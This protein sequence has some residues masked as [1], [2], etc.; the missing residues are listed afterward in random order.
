M[1]PRRGRRYRGQTVYDS[2]LDAVDASLVLRV[3]VG[4]T[5]AGSGLYAWGRRSENRLGVLMTVV[6]CTYLGWHILIQAHSSSLFTAGIWLSDSWTVLF[7]LFLLSFPEGR[8]NTKFDL[9]ILAMF[10]VVAFPLEFLWLLFFS[11]GGSPENALVVW[12]NS[13]VAD[14]VDSAQRALLVTACVVLAVTL[15]RRWIAASPP[16]RRALIP[17]VVGSA[18]ILVS[19]VMLALDKFDVEFEQRDGLSSARTSRFRSSFWRASSARVLHVRQLESSSSSCGRTP[20]AR[21]S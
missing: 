2:S 12:S 3:L 9:V 14:D 4:L 17:A 10:A 1:R 7:V 6:G 13:S 8:L 16:L 20:T 19:L 18:A 5:F 21:S 11:T 15:W